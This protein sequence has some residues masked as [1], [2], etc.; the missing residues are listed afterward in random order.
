[1]AKKLAQFQVNRLARKNKNLIDLANQYKNSSNALAGEYERSFADYTAKRAEAMKPYEAAMEQYNAASETYKNQSEL[2][3]A[4][5]QSHQMTLADIAKQP[6]QQVGYY[7]THNDGSANYRDVVIE[8]VGRF[9]ED[10]LP[11]NVI[12]VVE[13][14]QRKI[15]KK[16]DIPRFDAVA[17][18]APVAPT[19][20]V[21]EEFDKASFDQK[22]ADLETGYKRE[23]GER[24]AAKTNA[25]SR[26]QAR[27]L[28]QGAE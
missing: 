6:Y 11:G 21:I 22:R 12:D 24:R 28:L 26:K 15:Y 23:L 14:N 20:P 27:P 13:N 16:R 5:L 19:A 1:M 8:G 4:R 17:P 7:L 25:V 9:R 2:Y 3:K 18:V 10:R